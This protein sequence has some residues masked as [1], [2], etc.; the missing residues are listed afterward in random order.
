[1]V[2][3]QRLRGKELWQVPVF[4]LGV[5]PTNPERYARDGSIRAL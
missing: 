2:A 3:G 5:R 4:F 1:M